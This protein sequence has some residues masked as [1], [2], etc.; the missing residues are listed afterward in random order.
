MN[1]MATLVAVGTAL[2]HGSLS[3]EL[4]C[5]VG[6]CD[7]V[8]FAG[9]QCPTAVAVGNGNGTS[10]TAAFPA[11]SQSRFLR[12]LLVRKIFRRC[13]VPRRPVR[14]NRTPMVG[15]WWRCNHASVAIMGYR[16]TD[17]RAWDSRG[18][19]LVFA[20]RAGASG[21]NA[22]WQYQHSEG[23]HVPPWGT[24]H[25]G[26]RRLEMSGHG[27]ACVAEPGHRAH[28][29]LLGQWLFLNG[30]GRLQ[31]A[32]MTWQVASCCRLHACMAVSSA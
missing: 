10:H 9:D 11:R 21:Q 26:G 31:S 7:K 14:S 13:D 15:P 16:R 27:L 8:A 18:C 20:R 5:D 17:H 1:D 32:Y 12:V 24:F 25:G 23:S 3:G 29:F 28:R 4:S 30:I 6:A 22:A 2:V 19:R